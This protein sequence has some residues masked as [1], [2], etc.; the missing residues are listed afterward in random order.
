MKNTNENMSLTYAE[1]V[2]AEKL[3]IVKDGMRDGLALVDE[4]IEEAKTGVV[5]LEKA[6]RKLWRAGKR[7][8]DAESADQ[9]VFKQWWNNEVE[10][11]ADAVRREKRDVAL[12]AYHMNL[13]GEPK[14]FSECKNLVARVVQLSLEDFRFKR[15]EPQESHERNYWNELADGLSTV[16][17]RA[18]TYVNKEPMEKWPEDRLEK[19]IT[20]TNPVADINERAKKLLN[21]E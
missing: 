11:H 21:R 4:A 16:V 14:N 13:D 20:F 9:F 17:S 7:F 12:R 5:H 18:Q 2:G 8:A 1:R 6:C 10:W 3:S 19:I 15:I